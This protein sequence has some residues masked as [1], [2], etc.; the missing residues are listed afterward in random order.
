MS[1]LNGIFVGKIFTIYSVRKFR[2]EHGYKNRRKEPKGL[3][4]SGLS[5]NLYF[6]KLYETV[7]FMSD[8]MSE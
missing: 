6:M 3:E 5:M 8:L 2:N 7:W 1:N 4:S